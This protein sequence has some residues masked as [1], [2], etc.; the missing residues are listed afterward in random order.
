M[1]RA[2]AGAMSGSMPL[3]QPTSI[4]PAR[5]YEALGG[6]EQLKNGMSHDGNSAAI[7]L[8]D[9]FVHCLMFAVGCRSCQRQLESI[10]GQLRTREAA[11]RVSVSVSP[12]QATN[13]NLR[14]GMTS[15]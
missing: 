15:W 6:N 4:L 13:N 1:G 14:I 12:S 8:D 3:S 2:S 9:R 10:V 5:E 7:E 11:E